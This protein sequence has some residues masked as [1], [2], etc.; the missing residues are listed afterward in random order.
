M[1]TSN[2]KN[3][4]LSADEALID[5]ARALARLRGTTL[6]EEFR[7]WLA[8]FSKEDVDGLKLAQTRALLDELTA[9]VAD[10]PFVPANYR[11]EPGSQRQPLRGEDNERETRMLKRLGG[12]GL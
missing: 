10:Q 2:M 6:N 4:T 9:P 1:Y 8:S 12:V 7:K 3:V 11:F 5:Q